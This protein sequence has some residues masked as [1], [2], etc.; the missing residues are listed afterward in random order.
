MQSYACQCI[1]CSNAMCVLMQCVFWCNV[2]SDAMS[3]LFQCVFCSNVCSDARCILMQFVFWCNVCS[4]AKSVLIRCVF[5]CNVCSV[6]MCVLMQ[7]EYW[8]NVCSVAKLFLLIQWHGLQA[9]CMQPDSLASSPFPNPGASCSSR[10]FSL[11]AL[12]LK[13]ASWRAWLEHSLTPLNSSTS[14]SLF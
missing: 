4:D 14:R 7:G 3:V 2:C 10:C 12:D 8:C 13:S 1:V 6:L 11:S 5:W 9:K